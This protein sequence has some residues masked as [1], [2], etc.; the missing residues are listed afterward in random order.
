MRFIYKLDYS[1][2]FIDVLDPGSSFVCCVS[3]G[4]FPSTCRDAIFK[5]NAVML[6][7][8]QRRA[9]HIQG[10]VQEKAKGH[11]KRIM[12]VEKR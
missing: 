5:E 12:E 6:P 10:D 8:R 4:K 3:V 1:P 7:K 9:F 2:A 11:S